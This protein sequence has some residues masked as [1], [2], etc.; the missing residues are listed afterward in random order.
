VFAADYLGGEFAPGNVL[1]VTATF[2]DGSTATASTSV[3]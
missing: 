2:S 3:N 1:A